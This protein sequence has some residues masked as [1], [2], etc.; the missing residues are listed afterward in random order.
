M[1]ADNSNVFSKRMST[2]EEAQPNKTIL[3]HGTVQ[4]SLDIKGTEPTQKNV[5]TVEV[6]GSKITLDF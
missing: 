4:I 3:Y 1:L 2:K 6:S 5:W